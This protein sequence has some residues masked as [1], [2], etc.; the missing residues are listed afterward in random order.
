M[1]CRVSPWVLFV[2]AQRFFFS[3]FFCVDLIIF[4]LLFFYLLFVS[5]PLPF[6]LF[7][8][9]GLPGL[10]ALVLLGRVCWR[11]CGWQEFSWAWWDLFHIVCFAH[12]TKITVVLSDTAYTIPY[13]IYFE[14]SSCMR[15]LDDPRGRYE[16]AGY[17]LYH[18]RTM[19]SK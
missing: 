15:Y 11:R 18:C 8:L 7:R 5:S 6:L 2:C 3:F 13:S 9:W 1:L 4:S 10:R 16:G 14:D 12:E 17:W 19:W